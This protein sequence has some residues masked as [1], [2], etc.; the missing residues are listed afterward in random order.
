MSL[1][2]IT[3]TNYVKSV[4]RMAYPPNKNNFT[5]PA[6][7]RLIDVTKTLKV[8]LPNGEVFEISLENT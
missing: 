4:N 7:T 3:K 6:G 2:P 1:E 8:F 5:I